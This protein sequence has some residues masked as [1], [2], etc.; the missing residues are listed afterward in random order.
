[1][2]TG[3]PFL[4]IAKKHNLDYGQVLMAADYGRF[5]G[6]PPGTERSQTGYAAFN[7][8]PDAAMADINAASNH[9]AAQ[10]RGEV[11]MSDYVDILT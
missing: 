1:M 2:K 5:T 6:T 7:S 9:F 3:Y 4:V 11:A 10:Q 8:I